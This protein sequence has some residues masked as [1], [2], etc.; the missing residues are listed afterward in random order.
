MKIKVFALLCLLFVTIGFTA[1]GE[2]A[3]RSA[4][5]LLLE[6]PLKINE[7]TESIVADLDIY[8]PGYMQKHEIPGLG[9][10]L[11]RDSQVVWS[12]GY[13]VSNSITKEPVTTDTIFAMASNSK[14]VTSYIA[15]RLVD[16]G[17]LSL[18]QPLNTYLPEPYLPDSPYRDQIAMRHVASHSSGMTQTGRESVF[19]PGSAYYYSGAGIG[20]LQTV[21][22]QVS[23]LPLEELAQYYVFQPLEMR[24]ASFVNRAD[25]LPNTA[26]GHMIAVAPVMVALIL[27]TVMFLII[28]LVGIVVT[29]LLKGTWRPS[30]RSYYWWG[31]AALVISITLLILVC[32]NNTLSET[33]WLVAITELIIIGF[34]FAGILFVTRLGRRFFPN[35][36]RARKALTIV[37]ILTIVI[38][39]LVVSTNVRNLPFP[40]WPSVKADGGGSLRANT[41]DMAKFLIELSQP[42]YLSPELAEEL[43][44]PQIQLA[45]DLSWGLGMGIQKS[46]DGYALWQWGQHL[47]SQSIMIIYPDL[48]FGVVVSTNT[49]FFNPDA[50]LEIAH[51]AIGGP[52]STIR[53]AVHLNYNYQP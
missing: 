51:R 31:A 17:L 15:L 52:I 39:L 38:G 13:G 1:T 43:R 41:S 28:S 6:Q 3:E 35:H 47:H 53:N 22:E 5:S 30:S 32:N 45:K 2:A 8:I 16:Q 11:I 12:K 14:V 10:S 44:T 29:R 34:L 37:I 50:A 24:S 20:Y 27:F 19:P 49:D 48:G 26:N 23:G 4:G 25:L 7:T 18:D 33:G 42:Q 40:K 36:S 46:T 21:L 9:I